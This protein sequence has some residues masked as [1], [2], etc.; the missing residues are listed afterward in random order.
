MVLGS[1]L[2]SSGVREE[3]SQERCP[4]SACSSSSVVLVELTAATKMRAAK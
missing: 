1:Q 4:A 3:Q 2:H